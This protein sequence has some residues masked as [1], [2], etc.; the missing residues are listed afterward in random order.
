VS[1]AGRPRPARGGVE[2]LGVE[3]ARLAHDLRSAL[4]GIRS[5]SQVLRDHLGPTPDPVLQR[6][7]DGIATGVEQQVR[8]IEDLE[9]KGPGEGER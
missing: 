8:L 1:R 9:R 7:L 3:S 6:A 2:R 5:W 4:N